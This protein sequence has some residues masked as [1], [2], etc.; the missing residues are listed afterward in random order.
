[1]MQRNIEAT[2]TKVK[3]PDK[4]FLAQARP[5]RDTPEFAGEARCSSAGATCI[6]APERDRPDQ[7]PAGPCA[8][9]GSVSR[10][11][12]LRGIARGWHSFGGPGHGAFPAGRPLVGPLHRIDPR[13]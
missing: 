10:A 5:R 13:T 12:V 1:M 8:G 9:P 2:D 7:V 6:R 3:G 4:P 11:A